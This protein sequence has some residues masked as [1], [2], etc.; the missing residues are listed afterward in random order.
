METDTL[1]ELLLQVIVYQVAQ[2]A[3]LAEL[4]TPILA[5]Q[6]KQSSSLANVAGFCPGACNCP[7]CSVF[8][9]LLLLRLW[10]QCSRVLR[11]PEGRV[12]HDFRL[13]RQYGFG[14][15]YSDLLRYV[16]ICGGRSCSSLRLTPRLQHS[17]SCL[18]W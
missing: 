17:G 5:R 14:I 11:G 3:R 4:K 13:D 16:K 15:R 18:V 10:T 8:S 9:S 6:R 12:F 1:L 2:L 7:T